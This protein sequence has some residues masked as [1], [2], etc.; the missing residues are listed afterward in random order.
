M[1][2]HSLIVVLAAIAATGSSGLGQS[3]LPDS[4]YRMAISQLPAGHRTGVG[5]QPSDW[6]KFADPFGLF[7][8]ENG[9]TDG[10]AA[11]FSSDGRY[12]IT[13]NKADGRYRNRT[14]D[15]NAPGNS[16]EWNFNTHPTMATARLRLWNAATGELIWEK[17]RSRGAD[18]NNDFRPDDQPGDREDEI[19]IASF[20]PDDAY[21]AAGGEDDKIEIW[22]IKD[23]STGDLLGEPV[24]VK[25]LTTDA[26]V[27][28][29]VYSHS[30]DLLLAGTED[31]GDL[32]VFVVQGD[33]STWATT[34]VA[35]FR[36]NDD[37][38]NPGYA[39]NSVDITQDDEYV[40]TQGTNR[41]GVFWDLEVT[42]DGGGVI[43][44]VNLTRIATL[45]DTSDFA[46]SGR[47]ARFS[48]D[49]GP[50]GSAETYL[51]LTNE[52]DY[53]TRVYRVEDL[54]N[55]SGP[56]NDQLQVPQPH[57]EL[58]NGSKVPG[59]LPAFG[60]EIEPSDFT[61]SGRFFIND[62]DSRDPSGNPNGLVFPGFY[63]VYETAE[64]SAN[65]PEEEPDPI[66]LQRAL[67][68][69]FLSFN[70]DD[71]QLATG[72]GDGTL[73]VWDVTITPART[74]E[75]EAFNEPA[76]VAQRWTLE[77]SQAVGGGTSPQET[78]EFF[79]TNPGWTTSFDAGLPSSLGY[80]PTHRAAGAMEG[81]LGGTIV[82]NDSFE[83]TADVSGVATL[84]E[85]GVIGASGR[86]WSGNVNV[87]A[88]GGG[89]EGALGHFDTTTQDFRD[90][91]IGISLKDEDA[92]SMRI[93]FEV[94]SK[95][96]GTLFSTTTAKTGYYAA[97]AVFD[98]EYAYTPTSAT[99][100]VVTA[101]CT[102][103]TG[104]FE[105]GD[106]NP[107]GATEWTDGGT[108]VFAAG[109]GPKVDAFG[110]GS[111]TR[112]EDDA[113]ENFQ[114]FIDDVTYTSA[115]ATGGG[116]DFGSSTDV[117][118]TTPFCGERG[119]RF[120][121]INDLGGETHRL[122]MNDFWDVREHTR[123]QVQFAAVAAPGV[124]EAGDFLR[125]LADLDEDGVF[126][127]TLAEFLPDDDGDLAW[128][129][130]KLNRLF[131]DD[132]GNDF[133]PFQDFFIDLESL[134]TNDFG[135]MIRFRLEASTDGDDEE[136]GFDSL[137][138]TG[139]KSN[140]L[141]WA[142][143]RGLTT[144]VNAA[145]DLDANGDGITNGEH[146]AFDTDPLGGH[147]G[148]EASGKQD[149]DVLTDGGAEAFLT[150]TLPVRRGFGQGEGSGGLARGRSGFA[151]DRL[152][153]CQRSSLR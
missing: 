30:G 88:G 63:R 6:I 51:T 142:K 66:W 138:V 135:G 108:I 46:G 113:T 24:L 116:D 7:D 124:F 112:T 27:D 67:S 119:S 120:I 103:V 145:F 47:E 56:Q 60:T 109:E 130:S 34:P 55:Y 62:G 74:I 36:H 22:R 100:G 93:R 52:R 26:A 152:F 148:P 16:Y 4:P 40:A 149:L 121:A 129:G 139:V 104:S 38:S 15:G 13:S 95:S 141:G 57:H 54:K 114:L 90:G 137:R 106:G 127:T 111:R 69:E 153:S 75:S 35:Q 76:A 8:K 37:A 59:T 25:T 143:R 97:G 99:S 2:T 42:R 45:G 107:I 58:R 20:S 39:I 150:L 81:E 14:P 84:D 115:P 48:N 140:Y 136:I 31:H 133:Y 73:R 126:E 23:A 50:D 110:I 18:Q 33:P 19:E 144:G 82:S 43:T 21:V 91:M 65:P 72:Q 102:L 83:Y 3:P 146:F 128:N 125:L 122:N 28:G 151:M 134:L 53:L 41:Q 101:T 147:P 9:I 49:G 86:L 105:D 96:G 71:T 79:A 117:P 123:R 32:E 12:I 77:G 80:S 94:R 70:H 11:Q 92:N 29:M 17:N 64:W 89:E 131:Q 118:Q 61:K 44:G 85:S 78:S 132:A 98:W 5:D 10:E 68:T 87:D 1:R